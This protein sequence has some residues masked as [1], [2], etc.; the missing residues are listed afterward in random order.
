MASRG[1]F[2]KIQLFFIC[3]GKLSKIFK[4]CVLEGPNPHA[5]CYNV[6][7]ALFPEGAVGFLIELLQ[8]Y[9]FQSTCCNSRYFNAVVKLKFFEMS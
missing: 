9:H 8:Y 5:L 7:P 6:I 1:C 2:K 3:Q 4:V